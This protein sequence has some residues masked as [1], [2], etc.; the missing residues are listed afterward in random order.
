MAYDHE[1]QEQLDALKA[2]WKQY[3]NL[4]TWF[5]IALLSVF[6]TWKAWG[7][8]QARQSAQAS[9]LFEEVMRL[10]P[11]AGQTKD[12]AKV[13]RIT[14]DLQVKFAGTEYA[15]MASMLAAKNAFE[16]NDLK[17]AKQLLIWV[18]E[19]GKSAEFK[20]LAKLRLASV[21]TDEKSYAEALTLL[22]GDFPVELAS[23]VA[24]RKGDVLA[25][26]NKLEDARAA[27]QLAMDKGSDKHPDYQLIQMK[28]DAL[29][30][31]SIGAGSSG[32]LKAKVETN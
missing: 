18:Q 13:L 26:Q 27:Y 15:S 19:S 31:S 10:I 24:D 3:G 6:A 21:L 1:E 22:A 14:T 16:L 8:Y 32:G 11:E 20:S 25:A 30:G 2:W 28:L 5:L 23:S 29:G 7:V 12:Q 17:T 9:V 4:V